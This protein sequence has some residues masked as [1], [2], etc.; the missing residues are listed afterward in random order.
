MADDRILKLIL[1]VAHNASPQD[2]ENAA[3]AAQRFW[4]PDKW[5]GLSPEQVKRINEIFNTVTDIKKNPSG[6][7]QN[8]INEIEQLGSTALTALAY[9]G[10]A[11]GGI[12]V[13]I[14]LSYLLDKILEIR[15]LGK[16]DET[17]LTQIKKMLDSQA[18]KIISHNSTLF[19]NEK[20]SAFDYILIKVSLVNAKKLFAQLDKMRGDFLEITTKNRVFSDLFDFSQVHE[21][22][23]VEF[24]K[25]LIESSIKS[26]QELCGKKANTAII[27]ETVPIHFITRFLIRNLL[28]YKKQNISPEKEIEITKLLNQF[29]FKSKYRMEEA[30]AVKEDTETLIE[31]LREYILAY[32]GPLVSDGTTFSL[33]NLANLPCITQESHLMATKIELLLDA[34]ECRQPITDYISRFE[35]IKVLLL[36]K[37]QKAYAALSLLNSTQMLNGDACSIEAISNSLPQQLELK[38]RTMLPVLYSL[39]NSHGDE[40]LGE[41]DNRINEIEDRK[42]SEC[43]FKESSNFSSKQSYTIRNLKYD[44]CYLRN[45]RGW[46]FNYYEPQVYCDAAPTRRGEH[47]WQIIR[48][49]P[50]SRLFVIKH[51]ET[52]FYMTSYYR[53]STIRP[54]HPG[55]HPMNSIDGKDVVLNGLTW[56]AIWSIE[57]T[58]KYSEDYVQLR[59][60]A[61]KVH[62]PCQY[63]IDGKKV[64]K[65]SPNP[66]DVRA[67]LHANSFFNQVSALRSDYNSEYEQSRTWELSLAP[68]PTPKP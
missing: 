16:D 26:A 29:L 8:Q 68:Q 47:N 53:E 4:H 35:L 30:K 40:S 58:N 46:L 62:F 3:K 24:F 48:I 2:I 37:I 7:N 12:A 22:S 19:A 50:I 28:P 11:L 67:L 6:L 54:N 10:Q 41:I 25:N 17:V 56:G 66:Y 18:I 5:A 23:E 14:C 63:F 39:Y 52:G 21:D 55:Q 31:R 32:F 65:L 60:V 51:Q 61:A 59:P 36:D 45:D 13:N 57:L 1:N 33:I 9:I 64:D 49:S 42:L 44:N 38:F 20:E 43:P 34:A 15:N 27:P